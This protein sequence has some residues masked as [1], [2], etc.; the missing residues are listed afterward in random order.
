MLTLKPCVCTVLS[1]MCL[2]CV[3]STLSSSWWWNV[4]RLSRN[5]LHTWVLSSFN[6][7]GTIEPQFP[8]TSQV[9]MSQSTNNR[10]VLAVRPRSNRLCPL[11]QHLLDDILQCRPG[12][13]DGCVHAVRLCC[14]R[15]AFPRKYV[16]LIV[17]VIS[18]DNPIGTIIGF[19]GALHSLTLASGG[20]TCSGWRSL[21]LSSLG[22]DSS[23]FSKTLTA[24]KECDKWRIPPFDWVNLIFLFQA[25]T[26]PVIIHVLW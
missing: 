13:W 11:K 17:G 21:F 15:D 2:M 3:V 7:M 25:H 20:R 4:E 18:T 5:R 6:I 12:R 26:L 8:A 9:S 24:R 22:S 10:L 23:S 14:E 19:F 1:Y 16:P